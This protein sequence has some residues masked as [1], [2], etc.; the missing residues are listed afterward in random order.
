MREARSIQEEVLTPD[1]PD[2]LL[3]RLHLAVWARAKGQRE[4]AVQELEIVQKGLAE[5]HGPEHRSVAKARNEL[6]G[7]Y[8]ELGRL[9]QA[10]PLYE[11]AL[12]GSPRTR[13]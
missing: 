3:T 13:W 10:G 11:Q 5:A 4:A 2:V 9:E 12:T 6:A 8:H 1:H 7:T